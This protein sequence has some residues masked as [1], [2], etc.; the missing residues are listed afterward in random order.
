MTEYATVYT[1]LKNFQDILSQLEQS[2]LPVA[3]DE[4][5]Y[6]IAREI[7]MNNPT[8]FSNLVLCLGSFHL[9][10]IVMGAIGK[11]IDGSG[12]ETILVESKTFGKNVVRSVLDGTHYTRSLKGLL[13]L[14]ES[15][16]RLQWAEFFRTKGVESYMNELKFVKLMKA[17]VSEKK[18]ESS[19][20]H[21]CIHV[22][23]IKHD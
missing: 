17:S 23:L 20:R 4:G 8:E 1:A 2:Q 15:I 21:R 18:R 9:I 16:E 10:K 13:L 7:I 6:H 22:N 11:Y 5:V 12:A 14:C 19:K 3:C